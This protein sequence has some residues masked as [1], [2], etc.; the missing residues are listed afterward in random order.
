MVVGAP[1]TADA[2]E[3]QFC[4][5]KSPKDL[6]DISIFAGSSSLKSQIR[7]YLA[8][9]YPNTGYGLF[10]KAWVADANGA[11]SNEVIALY[12]KAVELDPAI[13]AA[14]TNLGYEQEGAAALEAWRRGL[15]LRWFDPIFVRAIFF[16]LK[17]QDC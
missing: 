13:E 2:V 11:P 3:C 17:D 14:W 1:R 12:E 6:L 7:S 8:E 5:G 15:E 10:G 16:N 9:A 4:Q